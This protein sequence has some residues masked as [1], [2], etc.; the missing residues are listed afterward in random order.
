MPPPYAASTWSHMPLAVG[1]LRAASRGRRPRRCWCCPP[2][3]TMHIGRTPAALVR[4]DRLPRARRAA[5]GSVVGRQHAQALAADARRRRPPCR[6]RR[7]A[8]RTCRPPSARRTPSCCARSPLAA[9]AAELQADE[10]RHH[11]AARRGCRR[12][13][14]RSRRGREPA[15]GAALDRDRRRADRVRADVLVQRRGDEVAE[16]AGRAWATA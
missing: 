10:V 4:R 2:C 14:R 7:A 5:A 16:D 6:P 1:D 8:P 3:A 9:V 11:A 12:R 13:A 15:H